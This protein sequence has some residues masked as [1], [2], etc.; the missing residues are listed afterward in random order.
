V[1]VRRW[2]PIACETFRWLSQHVINSLIV[3]NGCTE[4]RIC[5]SWSGP[6][7][8]RLKITVSLSTW[9]RFTL[10][11]GF[12]VCPEKEGQ[13]LAIQSLTGL[14][15]TQHSLSPKLK[16][17]KGEGR[18]H[19]RWRWWQRLRAVWV[20]AQGGGAPLRCQTAD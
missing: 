16:P 3:T 7:G 8:F 17:E 18:G 15:A 13:S 5:S 19:G 10:H 14:T 2:E 20:V 9:K 6:L 1:R 12:G 11:A 4:Y